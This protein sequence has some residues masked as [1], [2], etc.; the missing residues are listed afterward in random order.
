MTDTLISSD[1]DSVLSAFLE[2][3]PVPL[4]SEI[5]KW[6]VRYPEF[7]TEIM[8][9]AADMIFLQN[10][11]EIVPLSEQKQK[12]EEEA[13]SIAIKSLRA[14]EQRLSQKQRGSG[15]RGEGVLVDLISRSASESGP[16]ER[17][18]QN[19]FGARLRAARESQGLSES[20]VLTALALERSPEFIRELEDD[21]VDPDNQMTAALS[22]V[23]TVSQGYLFN[24]RDLYLIDV[25][26]RNGHLLTSQQ[27]RWIEIQAI[28]YAQEC[29]QLE[30]KLGGVIAPLGTISMGTVEEA[31]KAA[32]DV[33]SM[34]GLGD[35]PIRSL[36]LELENRGTKVLLLDMGNGDGFA[37]RINEG[38]RPKTQ[39]IVVG[40]R[41]PIERR[42]FTLAHELAHLLAPDISETSADHFAGAFLIPTDI[43][44][45]RF[46]NA[47]DITI[48]ALIPLKE[49]YGVSL[50]AIANRCRIAGLIDD[51]RLAELFRSF[52]N[53]DPAYGKASLE[54]FMEMPSRY[55]EL[56]QKARA[57]GLA[58]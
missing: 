38:D 53:S 51:K 8:E 19:T 36:T 49:E 21:V 10:E 43:V 20:A 52:H 4:P 30:E 56:R 12:S 29:L 41:W 15:D 18:W 1:K 14:A 48:Q 47:A 34:W 44:R 45:R 27:L 22:R 9:L 57:L 24:R 40:R 35:A 25:S 32:T 28:D 13:Y 31:E 42:R 46:R 11:R 58:E 37:M 6:R 39:V 2:A 50:Q 5:A 26:P 16:I 7:A 55:K 17:D 3:C 54:G 33:R 23:L